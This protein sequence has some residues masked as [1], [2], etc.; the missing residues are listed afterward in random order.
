MK[1][2]NIDMNDI[3]VAEAFISIVDGKLCVD[4]T[5][6]ELHELRE[7][8]QYFQEKRYKSS[9]F[10]PQGEEDVDSLHDIIKK[11]AEMSPECH[12]DNVESYFLN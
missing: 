9:Q 11:M 2:L 3:D 7:V 10:Y 4:R 12:D 6:F 8:K 1:D 5:V